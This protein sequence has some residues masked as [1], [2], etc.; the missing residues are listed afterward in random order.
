MQKHTTLFIDLFNT[1]LCVG[2]VP[3]HIGRFTADV[4]GVD[5]EVWNRACFSSEHEITKPTEHE[6]I[7]RTLARSIDSDIDDTLITDATSHR[8]R[9]FDFAL[10]NVRQE[11]LDA[12]VELKQNAIQLCLVSNASTAEVAAW[13]D[14]PLAQIFDHA[15]FSCDCGF[16]KPERSIYQYALECCDAQHTQSAFVG[17]GGSDELL[18]AYNIGLTTILTRQFSKLHRLDSVKQR[19]GMAIHHEVGHIREVITV[20][21]L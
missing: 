9:R 13:A 6:Q 12:L 3:E 14:S 4:L 17:D 15:V 20:L 11:V 8:Q 5:R 2:E 10:L 21:N 1:L 18:G 19:Q 16:K 7:I